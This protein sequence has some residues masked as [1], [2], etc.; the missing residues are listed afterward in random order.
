M[1]LSF[2]PLKEKKLKKLI[3]NKDQPYGKNDFA[4][5]QQL[6][7]TKKTYFNFICN[8]HNHLI[9]IVTSITG[10]IFVWLHVEITTPIEIT[11]SVDLKAKQSLQQ[12]LFQY[13]TQVKFV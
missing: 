2:L 1:D 5:V 3:C 10:N 6:W 11:I 12:I 8:K 9:F 4:F 7:L 13:Q